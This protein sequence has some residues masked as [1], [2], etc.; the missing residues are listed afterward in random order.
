MD[1]ARSEVPRWARLD[2][3]LLREMQSS[4]IVTD[5]TGIIRWCNPYAEVFL[6]RSASELLGRNSAEFA[7]AP[8]DDELALEIYE[9]LRAGRTWEGEFSVRH[10]DGSIVTA[11][12][13]DSPLHDER[14]R[15]V[16]VAS[17]S[18]DLTARRRAEDRLRAQYEIARTLEAAHSIEEAGDELL[19]IV[20]DVLGWSVGALWGLDIERSVGRG[21]PGAS[22]PRERPLGSRT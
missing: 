8:V 9:A 21:C 22:G 11:H 13:V 10:R 15:L 17:M 6:G 20:C 4:I 3:P 5:L 2:S 14:G 7:A 16:G 1:T 18:L 12:V 19:R